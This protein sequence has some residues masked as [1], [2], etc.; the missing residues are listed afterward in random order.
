MLQAD[1]LQ[2][3]SFEVPK[4]LSCYSRA[5]KVEASKSRNAFQVF[6]TRA[7]DE[8]VSQIQAAQFPQ[9]CD[10]SESCIGYGCVRQIQ[11]HQLLRRSKIGKTG[12]TDLRPREA[13]YFQTRIG[14]DYSDS[15]IVHWHAGEVD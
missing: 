8:R 5:G 7:P 12:I 3:Q 4:R 14:C 2:L 10:V 11:F 9:A 13:Q 1:C 15:R 6:E